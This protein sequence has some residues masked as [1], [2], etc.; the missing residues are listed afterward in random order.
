MQKKTVNGKLIT[1][2]KKSNT[3]GYGRFF[4]DKSQGMQMTPGIVRATLAND[5]Y[6]D[7]DFKNCQPTILLQLC[8]KNNW[9]CD[10]V[11][12]YVE[13]RDE[14]L[15]AY[16]DFYNLEKWEAKCKLLALFY[17]GQI[18]VPLE[19]EWLRNLNKEMNTVMD[20][21]FLGY[22]KYAKYANKDKNNERG[23]CLSLVLQDIENQC[24]LA[25]DEYLAA[26][27]YKCDVLV[28]DGI[29]VR[30]E[31]GKEITES[32]LRETEDFIC[33]KTGFRM[34][35]VEKPFTEF[36]DIPDYIEIEKEQQRTEEEK[37]AND[38]E[39]A[40][41]SRELTTSNYN[42]LK[43]EFEKT[44][45]KL[46][47]P[48]SFVRIIKDVFSSGDENVNDNDDD[49]CGYVMYTERDFLTLYNNFFYDGFDSLGE[50]I[51]VPFVAGN[52]YKGCEGWLKDPEMRTYEKIGFFP[53]PLACS[54][55]I[56]NTWDGFAIEK[57]PYVQV[58]NYEEDEHIKQILEFHYN[59]LENKE[60]AEYVLNFSA[61]MIQYPAK[62]TNTATMLR[63]NPGTGKDTIV[64][65]STRLL[66]K[67]LYLQTGDFKTRV[68]GR[69]STSAD[70][71]LLNVFDEL[72]GFDSRACIEQ[73]KDMITTETTT[74][75]R[76]GIQPRQQGDF[77][78]FMMTTNQD[79]ALPVEDTDRRFAIMDTTNYYRNNTAFFD[80]YY[81]NILNNPIAMRKWFQ[82]LQL[83]EVDGIDWRGSRPITDAFLEM[84]ENSLAIEVQFIRDFIQNEAYFKN[85][86]SDV[87]N[88]PSKVLYS[89]YLNWLNDNNIKIDDISSKKFGKR[90]QSNSRRLEMIGFSKEQ[91]RTKDN[92]YTIEPKKL[93]NWFVDKKYLPPNFKVIEAKIDWKEC[94]KVKKLSIMDNYV[95]VVN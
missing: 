78:K 31:N 28:F 16:K 7:L 68:C 63:G 34:G 48:I 38:K 30:K 3:K 70:S 13:N 46:K 10:A 80:N 47:N 89:E 15:S 36:L 41:A 62:K 25:M 56:Y 65:H 22:P 71:K 4:V 6:Y 64:L 39:V 44:H 94:E 55:K 21:V 79:Y 43:K 9:E 83:R 19:F 72:N 88:V 69:F 86:E 49:D 24:V 45:F 14:C 32:I 73:I 60:C 77:R 81:K 1:K 58:D 33:E 29:M 26:S 75:E 20:L 85:K 8:Q 17:G 40:R 18:D 66:G 92:K 12:Y 53:P 82:Y 35:V 23:S 52:P 87:Y 93:T 2:Y 51:K 95:K 11:K 61:F 42:D 67:R 90:L 74:V 54:E 57:I 91:V 50:A 5:N 59:A 76:K 27:G 37:K 84:R